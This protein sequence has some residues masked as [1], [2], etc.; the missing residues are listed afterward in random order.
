MLSVEYLH[1]NNIAHRD[2]KLDN[3]L[4]DKNNNVKLID[5]GFSLITRSFEKLN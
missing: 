3:I 4:L 1:N 2:I 5:F